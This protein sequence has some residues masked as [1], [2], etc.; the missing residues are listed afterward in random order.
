MAIRVPGEFHEKSGPGTS[1]RVRPCVAVRRP[2]CKTSRE[3]ICPGAMSGGVRGARWTQID[4]IARANVPWRP[5]E[6]RLPCQMNCMNERA[7]AQTGLWR[8]CVAVPWQVGH[9]PAKHRASECALERCLEGF[10]ALDGHK[11]MPSRERRCPGGPWNG[12]CLAR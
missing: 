4:A 1:G 7:R 10:E 6:W 12:D 9:L 8:P 5:V 2:S 3:P 11:S